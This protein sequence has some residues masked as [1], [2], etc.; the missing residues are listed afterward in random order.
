MNTTPD[1]LSDLSPLGLDREVR[2]LINE[3]RG[4]PGRW[5]A[6]ADES[7]VSYSWI[8]K[9]ARG[10]FANPGYA[11]LKRLYLLLLL[12]KPSPQRRRRRAPPAEPID[13]TE[14]ATLALAEPEPV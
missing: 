14:P 2:R 13:P 8:A 5:Q 12:G 7:G 11:T 1:P 3:Q 10:K 6:I 4:K 9:F